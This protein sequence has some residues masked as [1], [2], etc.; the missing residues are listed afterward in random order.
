[1]LRW[2]SL[3]GFLNSS[4]TLETFSYPRY[5]QKMRAA[6]TPIGKSHWGKTGEKLELLT[7][8]ADAITGVTSSPTIAV[9][10]ASWTRLLTII[11]RLLTR[12]A[13]STTT[14]EMM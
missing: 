9:M 10:T 5:D 13:A 2:K 3:S 4:A 8:G 1:M 6:L 14:R 7:D 12:N 11:P